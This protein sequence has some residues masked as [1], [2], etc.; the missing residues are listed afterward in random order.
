MKCCDQVLEEAPLYLHALFY[1]GLVL[2]KMG[3]HQKAI[4]FFD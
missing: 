4:S 3:E 1:K 2:G